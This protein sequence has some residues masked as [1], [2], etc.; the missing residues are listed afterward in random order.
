MDLREFRVSPDEG[1][2]E[3]IQRRLR[4]RRFLRYGAA[5]VVLV[6]VTT[7]V[8][9]LLWPA[10]KVTE[11]VSQLVA[12]QQPMASKT[13]NPNTNAVPVQPKA[14]AAPV[15]QVSEDDQKQQTTPAIHLSQPPAETREEFL[16]AAGKVEQVNHM[17]DISSPK[18]EKGMPSASGA[19]KT[20][21]EEAA[22]QG[23][24]TNDTYTEE[25]YNA[26]STMPSSEKGSEPVDPVLHADNQMWAPNV[27]VPDGD[28]DANRVF[29]MHFTSAVSEFHIY[30]Y[31]RGGRQV[32]TSN[33]PSFVWDGTHNGTRLSQG[34]YVWVAKFRDSAGK[35]HQEQ[36]TVTILR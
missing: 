18:A 19:E 4:L 25:V 31:N 16:A 22:P 23:S 12:V 35:P 5:T 32:F 10:G 36:G 21:A 27:I 20:T 30:I 29:K 2:Y 14:Q 3:K 15:A 17:S 6:A 13:V 1:L 28:I 11:P 33:D 26:Q 8:C 34:A 7:V 24:T 9:L